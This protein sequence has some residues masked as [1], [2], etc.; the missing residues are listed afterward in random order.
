MKGA[1]EQGRTKEIITDES[2]KQQMIDDTMTGSADYR[3]LQTTTSQSQVIRSYSSVMTT[4]K[5]P[6]K[7]Q[8]IV[9]TSLENLKLEE[10]LIAVGS[11]IE[12]KNI[13]FS[14]RISNGRICIYLSSITTVDDFMNNHGG[15]IRI[16]GEVIQTRRL[17]T[18][19]ERLLMSNVCP[20]IPHAVIGQELEKYGLKL[21]SPISFLK[22]GTNHP[23]YKHILSFRRQVYISPHE[24]NTIPESIVID[25]ENTSYRIF[26]SLDTCFICKKPDHVAANCTTKNDQNPE[27]SDV[28]S[29]KE[30]TEYS[31]LLEN[32]QI[33]TDQS[34]K[35][36]AK[37]SS[38]HQT[39]T[40][41]KRPISE[42]STPTQTP[43]KIIFQKPDTKVLK[44]PKI[45]LNNEGESSIEKSMQPTKEMF[46]N[47]AEKYVLN[48]AQITDFF[49]NVYGSPDP[50][51]I[52][53][54]YTNDIQGLLE[55]LGKIYPYFTER[56]M[57]TRCTNVKR[58]ITKQLLMESISDI[59]SDASQ[60]TY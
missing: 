58:K 60:E 3:R 16:N 24:K 34:I 4:P 36:S 39:I 57:K 15:K 52:A 22:I 27:I 6:S 59:E 53:K 37:T 19:N 41:S 49:E 28:L 38:E 54:T 8:A 11:L 31:K 42:P 21:M 32:S 23:E 50:L 10:Y 18:P 44:K 29:H 17:I 25:H 55:M 40:S 46:R 14:S 45:N 7:K 48:H 5:F 20:T 9:F 56:K 35:I 2:D 26:L 43:E 13:L 30:S 33:G 12:P 51:S 47:P 1:S